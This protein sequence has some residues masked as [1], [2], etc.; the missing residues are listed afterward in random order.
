VVD[1][2]KLRKM[3]TDKKRVL[4]IS[5]ILLTIIGCVFIA[6][7]EVQVEKAP[8]PISKQIKPI[9]IIEVQNP[10]KKEI[11]DE[12]I[13]SGD[14]GPWQESIIGSELSGVRVDEILV[15]VGQLVEKNQVLAI[16]NSETILADLN[17]AKAEVLEAE[18][19]LNQAKEN[20]DRARSLDKTNALSVQQMNQYLTVEAIAKA[21]LESAIANLGL[22]K[23]RMEQTK[24]K[25]PDSGIVSD[26][27]VSVGNIVSSGEMFKIISQ[28]KLQWKPQ[29]NVEKLDFFYK[30]QDIS[31]MAK[32]GKIIKA[33]VSEISPK[34][35]IETRKATIIVNLTKDL[36]KGMVHSGMSLSGMIKIGRKK[37]FMVNSQSIIKKNNENYTFL[38]NENN[39]AEQTKVEV[40]KKDGELIEVI[41]GVDS[42]D[43]IVKEIPKDL[44]NGDEVKI[45][46]K[47]L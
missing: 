40:G 35:N 34:V 19:T 28:E 23:V 13:V 17:I 24:I 41:S 18:A 29:I 21:K 5:T 47:K 9:P 38:V 46:P 8:K 14:V 4:A 20:A 22:Q 10:V 32:T 36:H 11:D 30:G 37:V 43:K 39:K 15:D 12:L 6:R 25:A 42:K 33:K 7:N 44:K 26:R 31:I 27:K 1:L 3:M 2:K 16:L 45:K